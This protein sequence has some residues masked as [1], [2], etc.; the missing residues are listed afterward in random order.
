MPSI[1][2]G[3]TR[4]ERGP[5]MAFPSACP[6]WTCISVWFSPTVI[7]GRAAHR[8]T[9]YLL[10]LGS[11]TLDIVSFFSFET[12]GARIAMPW[13]T[14]WLAGSH[15]FVRCLHKHEET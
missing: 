2:A 12:R 10:G 4:N 7:C 11:E 1:D 13:P 14:G 15:L 8:P 5:R 6:R 3:G 9:G